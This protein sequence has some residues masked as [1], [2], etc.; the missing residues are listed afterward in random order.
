MS[1]GFKKKLLSLVLTAV[2]ALSAYGYSTDFFGLINNDTSQTGNI[3]DV[4]VTERQE[5]S[6]Q[7]DFDLESVID[8]P[9][10]PYSVVN[11]NIPTFTDK[12][13][14]Q[15]EEYKEFAPLDN[16]GRCGTAK[17]LIGV[18][19]LPTEERGSIGMVKPSGWHTVRYDDLISDRYLYNRCHLIAHSLCG[20]NAN[21]EN[22]ITGTRYMNVEG[23]LPFEM[24][25]LD[26][27]RD[28]QNHVLYKVTPI[29]KDNELVARGVTMEAY[30][31]EDN[32]K[33]ICFNIY[34]PNIQP[35]IEI[36][37]ATGD[38]KRAK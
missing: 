34:C 15:T 22:L 32:G 23:M 36:D 18:D 25:V 31:I 33:G 14:Q 27:V 37:Y 7:G 11:N 20:E 28:T 4:T 29:F 26:Y 5:N 16:L 19:L 12:E 17:A 35:D 24:E 13:K 6:S 30:S 1:R 21:E 2:V 9:S 38:S 10:L 8:N 3:N